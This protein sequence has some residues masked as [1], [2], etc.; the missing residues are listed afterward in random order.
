MYHLTIAKLDVQMHSL[1]FT[2]YIRFST[3]PQLNEMLFALML[4]VFDDVSAQLVQFL[5]MLLITVTL[6]GWGRR[7]FTQRVGLWSATLWLSS[8]L[9]IWLGASAYV[10]IGVALFVTLGV[11]AFLNW[12]RTD[13][14]TWL[15]LSA[16]FLAFGAASKYSGLFPLCIFG[17]TLSYL[18]I[19]RRQLRQLI[20]FT[21]VV[22]L[23]AGPWY[24]RNYHLTRN[25]VFP[26]AGSIFGYGPWTAK[27]AANHGIVQA[28]YG[29]GKTPKAL[30]LLP[31]NLAFHQEPFTYAPITPIYFFLV[32]FVLISAIWNRPVRALF[33]TTVALIFFWFYSVQILRI[34]IVAIPIFSLAGAAS[35]EDIRSRIPGL[36]RLGSNTGLTALG[37]LILV[38]PG[39][40]YIAIS[41]RNVASIYAKK[42]GVAEPSAFWWPGLI[43]PLPTT[44]K[45]RYLYLEK[46]L[47]AYPAIEFLNGT[48]GN[49]Y[50][51]YALGD[52]QLAYF[53]DGKFMGDWFGPARFS[54]FVGKLT[55]PSALYQALKSLGANFFLI[56]ERDLGQGTGYGDQTFFSFLEDPFFD[57]HF[58]IVF[59][60][61]YL[62]TFEILD[63]S[64]LP[65]E[66][67]EL[68][69][70]GG[71]EEVVAGIPR[72]WVPYGTPVIDTDGRHSLHGKVAVQVNERNWL[73]QR[74]PATRDNI[75]MLRN[76][77]QA[78]RA[79]QQA[80]LQINW[81]D[82]QMQIT[83]VDIE[84]VQADERWRS[85]IMTTEAP[86][87]ARWADVYASVPDGSGPIWLD[88][89]SFT[90]IAYH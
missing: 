4:S 25:P 41:P 75:Y 70:N 8:P 45:Q 81:L 79:G 10:D 30:F 35:L 18:S 50:A 77:T 15:L 12:R 72:F 88:D 39:W 34:L 40:E 85:H 11:Y 60:R 48:R 61:P 89:L 28:A 78:T 32:P 84:V 66:R 3:L 74:V 64:A 7:W 21:I 63:H 51:L 17:L 86:D 62:I 26:E 49:K 1:V 53:A 69:R 73:F 44:V 76:T 36:R 20:L 80:R 22:A 29:S 37:A 27:D 87:N 19:R 56:D 42:L 9:V 46:Q 14:E 68:L 58:K 43:A 82:S 52:T 71:F 6:Y 23:I 90:Q 54:D 5:M 33:F 83:R 55:Q 31:W 47:P 65:S 16:A 38:A 67:Q 24:V 13:Q 57:T 2:P 59:A